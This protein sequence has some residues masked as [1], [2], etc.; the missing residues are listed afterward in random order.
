MAIRAMRAWSAAAVYLCNSRKLAWPLMAA[1]TLAEH[2]AS[3]RRRHAALRNPCAEVP[4]GKRGAVGL[5]EFLEAGYALERHPIA[6][7]Q[8]HI[9]PDFPVAVAELVDIV[10]PD[11]RHLEESH[12]LTSSPMLSASAPGLPGTTTILPSLLTSMRATSKPAATTAL[13]AAVRSRWRNR[14]GPRGTGFL[15]EGD[16]KGAK[17]DLSAYCTRDNCGSQGGLQGRFARSNSVISSPE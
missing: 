14:Q 9:T 10:E 2:P 1:M 12:S 6:A 3:A 4:A 8:S 17:P 15:L 13:T 7:R 16:K 11:L 5:H